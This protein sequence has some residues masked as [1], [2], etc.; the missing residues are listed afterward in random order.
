MVENDEE[1]IQREMEVGEQ[2]LE[3]AKIFPRNRKRSTLVEPELKMGHHESYSNS[4]NG[5][6]GDDD[7]EESARAAGRRK[8]LSVKGQKWKQNHQPQQNSFN[9]QTIE[10]EIEDI[11]TRNAPIASFSLASFCI[12]NNE[13]DQIRLEKEQNEQRLR[14]RRTILKKSLSER[15]SQ[16]IPNRLQQQQQRSSGL[17]WLFSS[18]DSTIW[19]SDHSQGE[20][21]IDDDRVS[22]ITL[23][24]KPK[25][26]RGVKHEIIFNWESLARIVG[27]LIFYFFF[28]FNYFE[29]LDATMFSICLFVVVVVPVSCFF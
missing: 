11:L 14:Q 8:S 1:I 20:E 18:W 24:K 25:F 4:P 28:N 23:V 26:I 10:E 9:L 13:I 21:P 15:T 19:S 17:S 7:G 16:S 2:S 29:W 12:D 3:M 5:G 27:K 22:L 6:G